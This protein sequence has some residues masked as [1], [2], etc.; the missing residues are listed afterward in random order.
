MFP[1]FSKYPWVFPTYIYKDQASLIAQLKENIINPA[2]KRV[3]EIAIERAK[4]LER[5]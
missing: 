3:K 2:E 1:D 4:R 5:Q